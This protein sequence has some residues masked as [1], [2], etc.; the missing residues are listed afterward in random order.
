MP[1]LT[2]KG[3][4]KGRR[5][6][7]TFVRKSKEDERKAKR[8][9]RKGVQDIVSSCDQCGEPILPWRQRNISSYVMAKGCRQITTKHNESFQFFC[10]VDCQNEWEHKHLEWE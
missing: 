5:T 1:K 3:T 6:P 2:K 7:L 9:R 8:M 4:V 10:S